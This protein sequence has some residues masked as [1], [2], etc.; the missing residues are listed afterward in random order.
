MKKLVRR[1]GWVGVAL[2]VVALA[3]GVTMRLVC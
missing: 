2:C 3:L 1:L